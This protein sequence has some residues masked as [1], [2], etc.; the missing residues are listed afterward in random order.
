MFMHRLLHVFVP[1]KPLNIFMKY[2]RKI[3]DYFKSFIFCQFADAFILGMVTTTEFTLLGCQYSLALGPFLGFCNLIPYFGSIIGSALVAI[4]IMITDGFTK[5][6][7]AA[8]ML[9]VTQQLDGNVLQPKLLSGSLQLSPVLI[10]ISIT[11]GGA[12]FGVIGMIVAIPIV[13][14]VK[15]IIEDIMEYRENQS[16]KKADKFYKLLFCH[17]VDKHLYA[18]L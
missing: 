6:L 14:I 17:I 8:V 10:I 13:T 15:N 11:V 3:N 18:N 12:Y 4:I 7:I 1:I 2:F 5:G 9:L 16:G